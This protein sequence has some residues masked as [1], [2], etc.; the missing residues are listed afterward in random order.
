MNKGEKKSATSSWRP[1]RPRPFGPAAGSGRA[2]VERRII[3]RSLEDESYRQ[4]LLAD[5]HAAL[6]EELGTRLPAEVQVR[7]VEETAETIYLVLPSASLDSE[8]EELSDQE[9]EAVAGGAG[10]SSGSRSSEW[11]AQTSARAL[12]GSSRGPDGTTILSTAVC[13]MTDLLWRRLQATGFRLQVFFAEACCLMPVALSHLS[14]T[15]SEKPLQRNRP[16]EG[17]RPCR[18]WKV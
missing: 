9:L 5:P 12:V 15:L 18:A 7:A 2:E 8:S 13:E 14:F 6:E 16:G 3:Q 4:R 11:P 10:G 17:I 1:R